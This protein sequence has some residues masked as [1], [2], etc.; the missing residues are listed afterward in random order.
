MSQIYRQE[1]KRVRRNLYRKIFVEVDSHIEEHRRNPDIAA[2]A[3]Q[4]FDKLDRLVDRMA[5]SMRPV[6]LSGFELGAQPETVAVFDWE[7]AIGRKDP[8]PVST[9]EERV[10]QL[11]A[12]I[13]KAEGH[14][15]NALT[16]SELATVDEDAPDRV[17]QL[18]NAVRSKNHKHQELRNIMVRCL[19]KEGTALELW[20]ESNGRWNTL[21]HRV[22]HLLDL[23]AIDSAH[24][25]CG[26][27]S[28]A[29]EVVQKRNDRKSELE[30][31]VHNY[32]KTITQVFEILE[33]VPPE[34]SDVES[35]IFLAERVRKQLAKK[36]D[37][38]VEGSFLWAMAKLASGKTVRNNRSSYHPEACTFTLGRNEL[39]MKWWVVE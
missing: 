9:P 6:D 39:N 7:A 5:E 38:P 10:Q 18:A 23:L 1:F 27:V 34:P 21:H 20:G 13:E 26:R 31:E 22:N 32:E 24:D 15:W 2:K 25:V 36:V 17:V 12:L 30:A 3:E 37:A 19:G 4:L 28:H 16:S 11:E 8:G 29:I 33:G 35:V 14:L